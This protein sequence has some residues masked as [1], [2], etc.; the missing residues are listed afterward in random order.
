MGGST[1]KELTMGKAVRGEVV[2]VLWQCGTSENRG[3][4]AG[5]GAV[6]SVQEDRE[7]RKGWGRVNACR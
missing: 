7:A 6:R 1:G 5:G 2:R 4:A 3:G